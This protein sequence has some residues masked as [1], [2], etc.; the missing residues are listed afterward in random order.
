MTGGRPRV[1]LADDEL[2][3]LAVLVRLVE[4]DGYPVV[5]ASSGEQAMRTFETDGQV[6][7][8][9]LDAAMGTNGV[10][11]VLDAMLAE[12]PGLGIVLTS[13][14]ALAESL[15][16]VLVA[17]DGIFLRKPFPPRALLRALYDCLDKG[18]PD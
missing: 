2:Q 16:S 1:L 18:R 15:R 5:T 9:V 17:N 3:L 13:G 14:D 12:R 6:G 4:R 11:D 7:I 8:V 10:D